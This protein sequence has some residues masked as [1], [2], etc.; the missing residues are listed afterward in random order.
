MVG[1]PEARALEG[2][3]A[4][5][6]LSPA[7]ELGIG[8]MGF[9]GKTT[10]LGESASGRDAGCGGEDWEVVVLSNHAWTRILGAQ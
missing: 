8:P 2:V 5:Q 6:P 9:G 1:P 10:L 3:I 7:N 4:A